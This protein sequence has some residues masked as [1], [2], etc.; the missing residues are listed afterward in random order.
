[1]KIPEISPS[2]VTRTA[3]TFA[4]TI[5]L[6]ASNTVASLSISTTSRPFSSRISA[7]VAM[8]RS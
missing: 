4:S 1:V 8:A 6:T 3:P 5:A 7:R 2:C